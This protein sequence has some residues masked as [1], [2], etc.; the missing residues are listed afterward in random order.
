LQPEINYALEQGLL[1]LKT[2]DIPREGVPIILQ[3]LKIKEENNR[4]MKAETYQYNTL[5]SGKKV[6]TNTDELTVYGNRG[7]LDPQQISYLNLFI[8]GVIQPKSNYIVEP[9][10]LIL[11][12]ERVPVEGTPISMKFVSLF[13]IQQ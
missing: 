2:E 10:I 1:T 8:N 4:L 11:K 6:Y 13:L 9:G 12:A 7:I 3:Y 5:A